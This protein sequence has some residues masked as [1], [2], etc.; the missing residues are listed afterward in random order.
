MKQLLKTNPANY[1]PI[2]STAMKNNMLMHVED[3]NLA[4]KIFGGFILRVGYELG[5]LC[6]SKFLKKAFPI[7]THVDD[8]QFFAPV[9][10]G[11]Y[12]EL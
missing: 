1:V 12:I 7:I 2:C 10:I 4:G 9:E 6:A 11:T 3:K 8:V 5:W